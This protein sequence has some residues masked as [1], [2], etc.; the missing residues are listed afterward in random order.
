[1]FAGGCLIV[2]PVAPVLPAHVSVPRLAC[3]Y[4]SSYDVGADLAVASDG[5]SMLYTQNDRRES[6]IMFAAAFR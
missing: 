2:P 3:V 6:G 5:A 1:M 4:D